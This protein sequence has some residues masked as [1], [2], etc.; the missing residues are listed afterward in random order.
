MFTYYPK[1]HPYPVS[2]FS[3]IHQADR[4]THTDRQTDRQ[5]EK[6]YMENELYQ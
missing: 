5:N 1:W 6:V 4:Q 3:T 2:H